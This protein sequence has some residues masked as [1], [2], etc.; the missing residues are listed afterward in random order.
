MENNAFNGRIDIMTKYPEY[1][2]TTKCNSSSS[3]GTDIVSR[4]IGHTPV[5]ALFFSKTNIDALQMGICN[6]VFNETRGKYNI[7][8]QS[9][10]ELKI[11]MRSYY[12]ESLSKAFPNVMSQIKTMSNMA[13]S[14]PLQHNKSSV[15]EQV[16]RLNQ[17]VLDWSVS[18][19]ITNIS[20]FDKYKEDV[21]R[22][23]VP[24]DMPKLSTMAGTKSLELKSFF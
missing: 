20:Q 23:P 10:A 22:L 1:S 2:H 6:R 9:E 13:M 4:T 5:S 21:S 16:R 15:V 7:G 8:K 19:I 18:K 12:F 14:V 24:M 3:D 11:I 17:S